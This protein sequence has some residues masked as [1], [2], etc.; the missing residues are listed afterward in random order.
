MTTHA[1]TYSLKT[2]SLWHRSNNGRGMKTD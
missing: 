2:E 1:R